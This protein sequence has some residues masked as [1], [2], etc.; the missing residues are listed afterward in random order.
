M[1]RKSIR[2]IMIWNILMS[3]IT[4]TSFELF[5]YLNII[6]LVSIY[7]CT[8]F[9]AAKFINLYIK[10]VKNINNKSVFKKSNSFNEISNLLILILPICFLNQGYNSIFTNDY[11]EIILKM[12][13][14]SISFVFFLFLLSNIFFNLILDSVKQ[15]IIIFKK[16]INKIV[17]L[18]KKYLFKVNYF[19]IELIVFKEFNKLWG[20]FSKIFLSFQKVKIYK[21]NFHR[22]VK[23]VNY[24]SRL[25]IV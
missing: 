15:V 1:Q 13:S 2:T 18:Y 16:M 19:I 21:M 25:L 7:L 12:N 4:L 20:I 3:L 22:S 8:S 10:D 9:I 23:R 24:H 17:Y 14:Y 11:S 6:T 5:I